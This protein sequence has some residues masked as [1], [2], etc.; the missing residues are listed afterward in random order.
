MDDRDI[1]HHR[2]NN[3][4]LA[5]SEFTSPA[6]VVR[7]MGAMQA[8]DFA[9]AKWAVGLRLK[10]VTEREVELA[11]NNGTILRTHLM[12]PTWHFVVAED[13]HWLLALTAPRIKAQCASAYRNYALT[14]AIFRKSRN[15]LEK[16]LTGNKYLTRTEVGA[17]LNKAGIATD[18]NRFIHLLMR[19]ELDGIVCSGP[20]QGKQLTYALLEERV[21]QTKN[22]SRNEA[23]AELAKRY[24]TSHG[25]ATV[26]D[27]AWW[28]GLTMSDAKAAIQMVAHEFIS[29]QIN[30]QDY[31]FSES[32][33][34]KPISNILLLPNY[35]EY[36]ISYKDRTN[37]MNPKSVEVLDARGSVIFN[38]TILIDGQ[39][40]GTW[41]RTLQ[42]ASVSVTITPFLKFNKKQETAIAKAIKEY[43]N[44]INKVV[45]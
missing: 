35:D 38:H 43:G 41:K 30:G 42:K 8:Q 45:V 17:T 14:D 10:N 40:V 1:I 3:Q 18:D 21:P 37:L 31:F 23:L 44:F 24:L 29:E 26:A 4:H 13:I 33:T 39:I 20:V 5:K 11:Y 28:S 2:L 32:T 15:A 16:A 34:V 12:R 27:F 7:Y 9:G 6:E 36:I 19:A 25:P 22:F